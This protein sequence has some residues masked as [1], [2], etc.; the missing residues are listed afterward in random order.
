MAL[1]QYGGMW[2]DSNTTLKDPVRFKGLYDVY[3]R[4]QFVITVMEKSRFNLKSSALMAQPGSTL[5]FKSLEKM[6][7]HLRSHLELEMKTSDYVPY[8]IFMFTAPVI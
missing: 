3:S 4:F 2:L 5:A 8:N 6:M 7:E 1:Y